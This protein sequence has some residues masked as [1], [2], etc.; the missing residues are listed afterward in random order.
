[1]SILTAIVFEIL[2]Q[3]T[4]RSYP[5]ATVQFSTMLAYQAFAVARWGRTIGKGIFELEVVD[6]VTTKRPSVARSVRR[7]LAMFG[8]PTLLFVVYVPLDL[9]ELRIPDQVWAAITALW[10]AFGVFTLLYASARVAGKRALWDKVAG[11]MVRYR[12][13]RTAAN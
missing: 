8:I 1:V 11:T 10:V 5:T 4:D 2:E 13:T 7:A 3:I 6:I 12:T 9:A